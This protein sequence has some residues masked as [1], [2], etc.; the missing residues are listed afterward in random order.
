MTLTHAP[1]VYEEVKRFYNQFGAKQDWQ[2]FYEQPALNLLLAQGQ[3]EQ[4]MSVIEFGCGTGRLAQQ[5]LSTYLP[6]S[7]IYLGVEL[8]ETM[9]RLSRKRL[10]DFG[11]RA[12]VI[13]TD[14]RIQLA[15]P[16]ATFDRFIA[17]YVL[18]LLSPA[19]IIA[20]VQEA[21]RVLKPGG[22]LCVSNLTRSTTGV[23]QLVIGVWERVYA[24]RPQWVGGCR[25]I[26]LRPYLAEALWDIDFQGVVTAYAI[27]S[28]VI[29]AHRR[30]LR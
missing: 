18:D 8:S 27:P 21:H 23:S 19:D 7:A 28:E 16:D 6:V 5:L 15:L 20:L 17:T 1:L 22:Q 4:A 2:A 3:F 13:P 29:I 10:A 14:G 11:S 26:E 25:P 9:I 12:W 30:V 24:I